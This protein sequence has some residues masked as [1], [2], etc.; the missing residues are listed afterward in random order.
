[1]RNLIF[2]QHQYFTTIKLVNTRYSIT[3]VFVC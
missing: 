3:D 2:A 1:M